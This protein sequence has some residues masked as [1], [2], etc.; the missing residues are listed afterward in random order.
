V[1]EALPVTGLIDWLVGLP[2]VVLFLGLMAVGLVFAAG[3]SWLATRAIED[4]VRTRT[5]TSVTTVV[6]V[7]A[8]LY[9]VLVAFVIVNEW[10]TFN[11]AQA[12]VSNESAAITAAYFDAGV[13]PEPSRTEIQEALLSYDRS[14]ICVEIPYLADHE[15]PALPTRRALLQVFETVARAS[16]AA[17]TSAF[18]T[19]AVNQIG[20][21]ATARRARI[22]AAATPLPNLLLVVILA[23]S[24]ALVA[25]ASVLDTQHRRWHLVLTTALTILVALNLALIVTLNR[26]FD[27]AAT[28]SDAPLREGIP[29]A[30]LRCDGPVTPTST[31]TP[32]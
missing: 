11:D 7:V 6:G 15:G 1:C 25:V 10:Q 24:L 31:T 28:I 27:G 5:S 2:T 22:N 16:P 3:L 18:Y 32:R 17:Q 20:Q 19:S 12:Q 8:G 9:A 13:L 26:P 14:V 30:L 29:S 21:I 4:E 23:T